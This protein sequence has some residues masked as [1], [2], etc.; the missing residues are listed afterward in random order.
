MFLTIGSLKPNYT[1]VCL[2]ST[3]ESESEENDIF[4]LDL[5]KLLVFSI[6]VCKK[7]L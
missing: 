2:I 1:G 5:W 3:D 6:F 4:S 7:N